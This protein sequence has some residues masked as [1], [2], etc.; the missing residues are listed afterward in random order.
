[1]SL[2]LT[3]AQD[4]IAAGAPGPYYV[5]SYRAFEVEYLPT[6]CELVGE[7]EPGR[8]LEIGPG[9]GTTMLWMAEASWQVE[10]WDMIPQGVWIT[11]EL[12]ARTGATF[13]HRDIFEGPLELEAYDCVV[14]T[15]VI[16]H[17]KFRADTA[18]A[19]CK[20]MLKPGGRLIVT[21]LDPACTECAC[22]YETDWEAVPA[23]GT[24]PPCP[25]MVVC[26]YTRD[27]LERLLRTSFE[28]VDVWQKGVLNYGVCM[29]ER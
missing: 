6:V 17:L 19:T 3:E 28:Q 14:M 2:T 12:L 27:S 21:A 7:Q 25:D 11:S 20:A 29:K 10:V 15:Q 22:A 13:R 18:V 5:D 23:Y 1:M 8:V 24:A 4:T 26:L 9:W 16:A